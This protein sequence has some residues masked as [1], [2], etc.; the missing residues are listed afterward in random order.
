MTVQLGECILRVRRF[1]PSRWNDARVASVT[2]LPRNSAGA[3]TRIRHIQ[4]LS[5]IEPYIPLACVV[6]LPVD[7]LRRRRRQLLESKLKVLREALCEFASH[8]AQ[9]G[10]L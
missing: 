5:R 7:S 8:L 9:L 6:L 4:R 1:A 2:W 3:K 10:S